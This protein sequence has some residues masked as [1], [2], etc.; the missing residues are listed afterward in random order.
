MS[1]LQTDALEKYSGL[2]CIPFD[3][4]VLD[5]ES[6]FGNSSDVFLEI[7][8]GM[9]QATLQ[10][11][12]DNPDCNY[13]GVEVHPPGVGRVLN[14][15]HLAGINNLRIIRHDAVEVVQRMIPD[16]TLSGIHIFF[17]DPWPKKKHHKRRLVQ[18][19]FIASAVSKLKPGGYI[20]LV[21]DWEPYAE[22]MLEVL[23]DT[24]GI[25]NK[26]SGYADPVPW[27]PVTPFE[28]KGRDKNHVIREIWYEK[29]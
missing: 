13:I 5:Y 24:G 21:T 12:K 3:G 28:K 2:Y 23:D 10:I 29:E 6:V 14:E 25:R 17:P 16:G 15:I 19:D 1:R 22:W 7:G 26:Y 20:Y 4:K 11:A 8:F 9:G 27:R 18:K